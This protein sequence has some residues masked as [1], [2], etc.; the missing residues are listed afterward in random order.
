MVLLLDISHLLTK[1]LM[2]GVKVDRVLLGLSRG[3]VKFQMNCNVGV[4]TFISK[5]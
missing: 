2:E 5:E 1:E 3:E 4:V